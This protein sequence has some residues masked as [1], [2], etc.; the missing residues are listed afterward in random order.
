[1]EKI[2]HIEPKPW[3]LIANNISELIGNTPCVKLNRVT[4]GCCWHSCS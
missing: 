1:M 2:E 3:P 4:E